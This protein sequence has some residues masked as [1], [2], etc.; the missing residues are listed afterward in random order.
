MHW[1]MI[2]VLFYR[3]SQVSQRNRTIFGITPL[4]PSNS[5][6][7]EYPVK[8][9]KPWLALLLSLLLPGYGQLYNGE[10][11]KA[12]WF[13]LCLSLLPIVVVAMIALY[14]PGQWLLAS[15]AGYLLLAGSGW[16]YGAI[17]AFRSA[18][19]Q[20]DYVLQPWQRSGVYLLVFIACVLVAVPALNAYARDHWVETFRVPSGSM[21]PTVMTGDM[22]FADKRYNCPGCGKTLKRGDLVIFAHP[23]TRSHYFIKRVIGLPGEHLR[24]EGT[25]I[26]INGKSLSAGQ[27]PQAKGVQVT[28]TDGKATWQVIWEQPNAALPQTD[29]QIPTGQ[30]FM[31]GD[32]RTASNDSRF[33]GAVPLDGVIAQAKVVWLSVKGNQVRWERMG[34][35]L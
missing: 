31:M 14:V 9:R 23:N 30:V 8:R 4:S 11:N 10:V 2:V 27:T 15:G 26:Y 12:I 16:L 32:N 29:L 20:P 7:M 25:A 34:L 28:E 33:F 5:T 18:R 3:V 22:L 24:I 13:F 21:E 17:D 19:R 1:F 6:T 35:A